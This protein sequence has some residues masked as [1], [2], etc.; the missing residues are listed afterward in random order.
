MCATEENPSVARKQVCRRTLGIT[1]AEKPQSPKSKFKSVT[2]KKSFFLFATSDSPPA[3]NKIAGQQC[4]R[5][6][7]R[8]PARLFVRQRLDRGGE[9]RFAS[10]VESSR[11]WR[12][13]RATGKKRFQLT[14]QIHD[15]LERSRAGGRSIA[16]IRIIGLKGG[17]EHAGRLR[18]IARH[19]R[20]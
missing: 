12:P 18:R 10:A 3:I 5:F 17:H 20:G 6:I 14:E 4:A 15:P 2:P 13:D 8:D 7:H 9:Q 16:R 1:K 19:V 11:R